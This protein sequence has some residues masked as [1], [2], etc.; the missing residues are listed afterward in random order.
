MYILQNAFRNVLRNKGRNILLGAII[1]V[2]IVSTVVALMINNT[3]GSIIDDYKSRFASE[4]S[5]TPNMDRMREQAMAQAA[6]ST[7]R[8]RISPPII[9]PEQYVEFG[10]SQYL[11][12]AVYTAFTSVNSEDITAIDAEL[13]G[14]AMRGTV[15]SGNEAS[16]PTS[17]YFSLHGNNFG[18]LGEGLRDLAEGR[19]P[20]NLNE[21]II[22]SDLAEL[23][24]ISLGDKLSFTSEIF[25]RGESSFADTHTVETYYVL[26]V[27]G[28]YYDATDEY[29]QGGRPNA[30]TNRRNEI[31]TTYETVMA[32]FLPDYSGITISATYFVENPAMIPAFAEELY[33]KGLDP[34]FDVGTDETGYNR[35]I[36]PVEGLRSISITFMIIVLTFGG[37]I[38]ALLSSIAIRERKYEIGVLRAMGMKKHKVALGLWSEM[39][40]I[41]CLCL[42]LGLGIGTLVTQPVTNT[43]LAQQIQAAE[44]ASQMPGFGGGG[45]MMG[46]MSSMGATA[47]NVQPL[48]EI[49][50]ALGLDTTLQIMGIALL[51]AS[52]AALIAISRITKYEP[53]KILMERN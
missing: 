42:A 10:N 35:I 5:I 18:D 43:L 33:A 23:N 37:V 8:V 48:S 1:F 49:N 14:Q 38:I 9:P 21:A 29:I 34:I 17:F 24:G 52:F 7:G 46:A 32:P 41:T 51:L 53:I 12:G 6:G 25:L 3:T 47:S 19:M 11:Y 50:I 36:G 13:D 26:E 28:I 31:L 30:R 20:E 44:A 4:V 39:L 2:I 15:F 45:M 27:V 22:S 16:I 40:I